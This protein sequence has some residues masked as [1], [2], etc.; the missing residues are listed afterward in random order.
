MLFELLDWNVCEQANIGAGTLLDP[1]IVVGGP[2][3]AEVRHWG[4]GGGGHRACLCRVWVK[5]IDH[6][7]RTGAINRPSIP[8]KCYI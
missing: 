5:Y 6:L 2:I 3:L 8:Y 7:S 4:G 1:T